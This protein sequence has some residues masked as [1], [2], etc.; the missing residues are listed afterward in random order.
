MPQLQK[1]Q[2]MKMKSNKKFP[3]TVADLPK[4]KS[5]SKKQKDKLKKKMGKK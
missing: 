1:H 2:K 4:P 5:M 3:P